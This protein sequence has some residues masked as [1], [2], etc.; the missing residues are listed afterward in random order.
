MIKAKGIVELHLTDT[1]TGEKTVFTKENLITNLGLYMLINGTTVGPNIYIS[2][3]RDLPLRQFCDIQMQKMISAGYVPS[4][5]TSPLWFNKTSSTPDY[6]QFKQRFDPPAAGTSRSIWSVF[7][8][9][10]T[11]SIYYY[12][13]QGYTWR[14][15]SGSTP[16][17]SV[18]ETWLQTKV[19]FDA[20]CTQSDSQVLDVY[21]R[22]QFLM[23]DTATE[24]SMPPGF[25]KYA[26]QRFSNVGITTGL[27]DNISGYACS[28]MPPVGTSYA[29]TKFNTPQIKWKSSDGGLANQQVTGTFSNNYDL[30]KKKVSYSMGLDDYVGRIF[31]SFVVGS[32]LPNG[33]AGWFNATPATYS[34][35]QVVHNHSAESVKPFIDVDRL[36]SGQGS[37]VANAQ[38]WVSTDHPEMYRINITASGEP[39]TAS[40]TF[41]KRNHYGFFGNTY[42]DYFDELP[43]FEPPT[44]T[45][46]NPVGKPFEYNH[47]LIENLYEGSFPL[48]PNAQKFDNISI[49][50][51]DY[52]GLQ[53]ASVVSPS[54]MTW[55]ATTT[56]ALP[57]SRLQ[58]IA[59]KGNLIFAGCRNTGLW[60]VD[61]SANTVTQ[62]T[63][64]GVTNK[65]YGVEIGYNGAIVAVM[66]GALA[67]SQDDGSTWALYN[68]TTTPSLAIAGITDNNWSTVAY[69][70]VDPSS[71]NYNLLMLRDA[72]T[73]ISP[74]LSSV[75]WSTTTSATA[76][77]TPSLP[78]YK[79]NLQTDKNLCKVSPTGWWILTESTSVTD[80]WWYYYTLTFGTTTKTAINSANTGYSLFSS[81]F[82]ETMPSGEEVFLR[83]YKGTTS[84]NN[85]TPLMVLPIR[86]NGTSYPV[87]PTFFGGTYGLDDSVF[88]TYGQRPIYLG[89]GVFTFT[90]KKTRYYQTDYQLMQRIGLIGLDPTKSLGGQLGTLTWEHYSWNGTGWEK[91]FNKPLIDSTASAKHGTRKMFFSNSH[92]Y[93]GG[94][95]GLISHAI[96]DSVFSPN[97]FLNKIT[98]AM[99]VSSTQPVGQLAYLFDLSNGST[100]L[101]FAWNGGTNAN[102]LGVYDGTTWYTFGT[103]VTTGASQRIVFTINGTSLKCYVNGVQFGTT[104]TLASALNIANASSTLKATI[105]AERSSGYVLSPF[106]GTITNFQLW[107]AEW[108]QSNVTYDYNN[109]TVLMTQDPAETTITMSNAKAWYKH[110]EALNE[111]RTTST[112][113]QDLINNVQV[114]FVAGTVGISFQAGDFYN[115]GVLNGIWKDNATTMSGATAFYYTKLI[116]NCQDFNNAGIITTYPAVSNAVV[117]WN[118]FDAVDVSTSK[119]KN[120]SIHN[121]HAYATQFVAGDFEVQFTGFEDF[122]AGLAE[123]YL[124]FG[125][126]PL[127]FGDIAYRFK[128]EPGRKVSQYVNPL[129]A[130]TIGSEN[131]TVR[132]TTD[133]FTIKRSGN[134]ISW[135]IN[136]VS[137]ATTTCS[138]PVLAVRCH[139]V[140]ASSMY[141]P[142]AK[143]VSS[144]SYTGVHLGNTTNSTGI[145]DPL[146][147]AV[148][149]DS[150]KMNLSE[151][152]INGVPVAATG[153]TNA[154]SGTRYFTDG[155][156]SNTATYSPPGVNEVNV[157][158][159]GVVLCNAA[160]VGK[161]LT[162]KFAYLRKPL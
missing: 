58:Q 3:D 152:A 78:S 144:A 162:G 149:T 154:N 119:V 75:W 138:D 146:F 18:A 158:M 160:D 36:A 23:P 9:G 135:L 67:I 153:A 115:F 90:F 91:G 99:T 10:G 159:G 68:Q 26:A 12:K 89:K 83:F 101:S 112:G 128:V 98:V 105:G 73:L 140:G 92:K 64:S 48:G 127:G 13:N 52:T 27:V 22:I 30:F 44:S 87:I 147:W 35:S 150:P 103:R 134:T 96:V 49:V 39:G 2:T 5:E 19:V 61:K 110:T 142:S 97:E 132:N 84:A 46:D 1:K 53:W 54:V 161:T 72:T 47:G 81:I 70:R 124:S 121:S 113:L 55:N 139:F 32:S 21:Y 4:G 8:S 100:R 95:S 43:W 136:G 151:F 86:R 122:A 50:T 93:Q 38:S 29:G 62:L 104:K 117:T 65:C 17:L 57:V 133:I 145:F 157:F 143:I 71:P 129:I 94:E 42:K 59:V 77:P 11:S 109:Q 155:V 123:N 85:S 156:V 148:E 131:G 60:K 108:V 45:T 34:K 25:L 15:S 141:G 6:V 40:Y 14:S 69:V 33:T 114:R 82:F 56:P 107:N 79:F 74:T 41:S 28:T 88:T 24:G 106:A 126:G 80:T 118:S 51:H 137:K 31:G 116:R 125:V 16:S 7:L 111:G 120:N 130:A 102:E 37:V 66:D 76:G 63:V 20:A